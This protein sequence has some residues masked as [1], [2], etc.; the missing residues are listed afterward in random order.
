[1]LRAALTLLLMI[2]A[3]ACGAS[4]GPPPTPTPT[5]SP[6][7]KTFASA[8][9]STV[10]PAGWKDMTGNQS[11]VGSIHAGGQVLMLLLAAQPTMLNE[12]IDVSLASQPVP[13]DALS[14]YLQSV[15]HGGATNLSQLQS[16]S[17]DG[18][19]GIFITYNLVPS[20][21]TPLKDEDMVVNHGGDT[22]DIVLNTAQADFTLQLPDLQMILAKWKWKSQPSP[23][24]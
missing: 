24:S 11:A 10:V 23:T 12:H 8:K 6:S 21:G 7:A 3:A 22:Y 20:G 13:Q 9:F 1:M 15:S 17:L 4:S 5:P 14:G 2:S 19:T 16:F 18:D